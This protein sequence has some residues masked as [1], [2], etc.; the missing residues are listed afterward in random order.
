MYALSN[1]APLS[2][3]SLA[4]FLSPPAFRLWLVGLSSGVTLSLVTRSTACLLTPVWSVTI[5]W[6]NVLT[7][8]FVRRRRGQ[9]AGVD[10]DLVGGDDDVRDL[11]VVDALRGGR[12]G[13]EDERD[14][15]D[16]GEFSYSSSSSEGT[17]DPVSGSLPD[18][19]L[20]SCATFP[21]QSAS[22]HGGAESSGQHA[23]RRCDRSA[24]R[25]SRTRRRVATSMSRASA[26]RSSARA[27][28]SRVRT[29][30]AGMAE[31]LGRLLDAHVLDVAHDEHGAERDGQLVDPTLEHAADLGAQG[32]PGRRLCV[33]SATSASAAWLP[34]PSAL[35]RTA[36]PRDRASACAG[37]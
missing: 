29:V 22:T 5:C 19:M 33:S 23:G 32:G 20:G 26:S 27:R 18:W 35:S 9:L 21:R 10:V 30:A 8:A 6:P 3:L 12:G 15:S 2:V 14:G 25:R 1:A 4:T 13:D 28:K 37:A 17:A 7:S 36:R 24:R 34:R 31:R 16:D 11:R